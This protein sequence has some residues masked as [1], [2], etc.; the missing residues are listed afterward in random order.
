MPTPA[1]GHCCLSGAAKPSPST[2]I[3]AGYPPSAD[4][5]MT[6]PA[7]PP[8]LQWSWTERR[9][10]HS[11]LIC[12]V[13]I[14]SFK[15]APVAFPLLLHTVL[16]TKWPLCSL[17]LLSPL[18][19]APAPGDAMKGRTQSKKGSELQHMEQQHRVPKQ[20]IPRPTHS[21]SLLSAGIC[22]SPLGSTA[23]ECCRA[24]CTP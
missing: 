21:L 17:A 15:P 2:A 18:V 19:A 22:C 7:F 6:H 4:H 9:Q 13:H 24:P 14:L 5:P 16:V 23:S 10:D 11:C 1:Q 20:G 12:I 3:G 8:L